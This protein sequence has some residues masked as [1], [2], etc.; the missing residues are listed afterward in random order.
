MEDEDVLKALARL[1]RDAPNLPD[2]E[3]QPEL[4]PY[5]DYL[6]TRLWARI[7]RKRVRQRDGDICQRCGGP[8]RCV[9]CHRPY[10]ADVLRGNNDAMLAT[11]CNGCHEVIERDDQ[12]PCPVRS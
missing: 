10:D 2:P 8:G 3:V 12:G 1:T 9:H 7:R 4:C 5:E 11:V 6:Q